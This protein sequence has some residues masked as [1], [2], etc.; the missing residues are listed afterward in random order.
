MLSPFYCWTSITNMGFRLDWRGL[1][2]LVRRKVL[3]RTPTMVAPEAYW[4]SLRIPFHFF[5]VSTYLMGKNRLFSLK[6]GQSK[7][8][9]HLVTCGPTWLWLCLVDV[10]VLVGHCIVVTHLQMSFIS[11]GTISSRSSRG[12]MANPPT[13]YSEPATDTRFMEL[14]SWGNTVESDHLRM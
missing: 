3:R 1:H 9:K 12:I 8:L 10:V 11:L 6:D 2:I 13:A 5:S 7:Y 14:R 4:I